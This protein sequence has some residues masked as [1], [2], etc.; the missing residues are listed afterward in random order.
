MKKLLLLL[1]PLALLSCSDDDS[2]APN[3]TADAV[4][5]P[6]AW[7]QGTWAPESDA[8]GTSYVYS[9]SADDICSYAPNTNTTCWGAAEGDY[10]VDEQTTA[11]LYTVSYSVGEGLTEGYAFKKLEGN[12]IEAFVLSSGST[13]VLVK[14]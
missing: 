13:T 3:T 8:T 6:P 11:D 12:K 10:N 2:K 1:A 4:F 14:Q 5:N 9:F 7:I